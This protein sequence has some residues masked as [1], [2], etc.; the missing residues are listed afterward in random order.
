MVATV[1]SLKLRI[2]WANFV[3]AKWKIILFA[4]V[5]LYLLTIYGVTQA[6]MFHLGRVGTAPTSV[7]YGSIL[8]GLLITLAWAGAPFFGFGLDNSL[9]PSNFAPFV[10]PSR[11]L[12]HALILAT[13][14]GPGGFV[15]FAVAILPATYLFSAGHVLAGVLAIVAALVFTYICALVS[16]LIGVAVDGSLSH[17]SKWRDR[18]ATIATVVFLLFVA[19]AGAWMNALA[20]KDIFS[21]VLRIGEVLSW[22]PLTNPTA[23]PP[24]LAGGQ[25]VPALLGV[26]YAAVG[27]AA[28]LWLWTRALAPSMRGRSHPISQ[29]A[30]EA[31]EAGRHLVDPTQEAT[32]QQKQS[33]DNGLPLLGMWTRLGVSNPTSAIAARTLSACLGDPRLFT[34]FI[35]TLIF[36]IL[37]I[38]MTKLTVDSDP[39]T[40]SIAGMFIYL[41]PILMGSTMALLVSY[42]STAFWMHVSAGVKG[43]QDRFGRFLGSLLPAVT[44]IVIS[45]IAFGAFLPEAGSAINWTLKLLSIYLVTFGLGST[46]TGRYSI[47]VQPPGSSPLAS[48]GTG[49]QMVN[50]LI[51]FGLMAGGFIL[52]L[53]GLLIYWKVLPGIAGSLVMLAWSVIIL[54]AGMAIGGKV[55]DSGQV[56]LLNLIRSWPGH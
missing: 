37:G 30:R 3:H 8:V 52:S 22:T 50:M 25:Y 55:F 19:P 18:S 28:L 26:L 46:F 41:V 40:G 20:D 5:G 51:S 23:L 27:I 54:L 33:K 11:S 21:T 45:S 16:R 2:S 1:V 35:A 4:L 29:Q 6:A 12:A 49:N 15:T 7:A 56:K 44:V 42:D 14:V 32:R 9:T 10:A 24:L 31:I 34:S 43:W 38:A 36:P 48:K 17:S 47:G 13:M 39:T 53:P